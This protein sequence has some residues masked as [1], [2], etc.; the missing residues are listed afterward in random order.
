MEKKL[1]RSQDNRIIGGVAGGLAEYF[2]IDPVIVR[3]I[4]VVAAFGWGFSIFAYI[5]LW[6]IVPRNPN[7]IIIPLTDNPEK[8]PQDFVPAQPERVSKDTRNGKYIAASLLILIGFLGLINNIFPDLE[9]K[10]IFPVILILAG[11]F[12]LISFNGNSHKNRKVE[13]I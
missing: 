1:Y 5:L 6:I 12:I 3:I 8:M 2:D 9:F 11:V 13:E 7:P 4:F 10:V